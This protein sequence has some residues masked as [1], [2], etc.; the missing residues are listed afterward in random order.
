MQQPEG[1][2]STGS[3]P[4][5]ALVCGSAQCLYDDLERAPEGVIIGV[6]AS[7]VL[8]RHRF[9]VHASKLP[10]WLRDGEIAH[11]SARADQVEDKA[12]Q[13]PWINHWWPVNDV[14]ASS[15]WAA[16]KM[17][18]MMGYAVVLCGVPMMAQNYYDG[19][20]AVAFKRKNILEDYQRAIA[21]DTRWHPYIRSMSGFT[22][23]VLGDLSTPL[24]HPGSF[25][26]GGAWRG[27][28]RTRYPRVGSG[29]G[30]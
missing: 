27:N 14:R 18:V 13:Y 26:I 7:D 10:G 1:G 15:G 17:A 28:G 11:S 5:I 23:E 16:A 25:D 22:R 30:A 6:N 12:S 19:R 29:G 9:S 20:L 8:A 2:G 21:E 4:S 3:P 24:Q